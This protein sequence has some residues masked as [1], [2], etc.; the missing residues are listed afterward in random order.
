MR[1]FLKRV[2]MHVPFLKHYV[3]FKQSLINRVPLRNYM[4]YMLFGS[5]GGVKG[6]YW[7]V[8]KNSEVTHPKNIF[9]GYNSNPGTRP[10]CY[11]QGNGGIYIGNYVQFGSNISIISANHDIYD[12]SKHVEKKVVIRDYCWIG[13]GAVLL[14]GVELGERTIVG[15][16]TVVTKSFPD[17]NCVIAG[18]PAKVV[19][20][21]DPSQIKKIKMPS[22]YYGFIPKSIFVKSRFFKDRPNCLQ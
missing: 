6:I 1:R 22:E 9:V 2:L 3:E 18:N 4:E 5:Q 13:Q 17:G 7:P 21:L 11:I 16:G 15:A 19:K 12:Q 20:R 10:G 14:P 8:H